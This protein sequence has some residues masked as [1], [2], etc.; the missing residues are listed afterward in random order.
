[1]LFLIRNF[2]VL[3]EEITPFGGSFTVVERQLDFSRT[4][5]L[6]I[7]LIRCCVST[8]VTPI[9]YLTPMLIFNF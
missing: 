4:K 5:G 8:A 2:L 9:L 1:M 7:K 3:R 6:L